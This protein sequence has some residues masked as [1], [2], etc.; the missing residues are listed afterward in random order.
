MLTVLASIAAGPEMNQTELDR[1]GRTVHTALSAWNEAHGEDGYAAWDT[2]SAGDKA[3]TFSS[4]QFVIDNPGADPG[5]QH[6][7]WL[8][9]KHD[10]GWTYNQYRDNAKKHHPMLIPFEQLSEFEQRKDALLNALV[11]ALSADLK[12]G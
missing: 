1:I 8:R 11:L 2:L 10:D 4:V 12:S 3:S 7:Q 6:A 5:A 9:Q